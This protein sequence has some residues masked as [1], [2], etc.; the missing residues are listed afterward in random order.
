M[1][2]TPVARVGDTGSHGGTITTGSSIFLDK[3]NPIARV[4]DIYS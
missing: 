3:D 1:A 2:K 4:G